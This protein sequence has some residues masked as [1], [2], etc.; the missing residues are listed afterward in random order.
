MSEGNAMDENGGLVSN[1]NTLHYNVLH[2]DLGRAETM[3]LFI[4]LHMDR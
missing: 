4:C 3:D 1:G 2:P